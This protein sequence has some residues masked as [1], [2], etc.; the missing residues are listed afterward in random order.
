MGAIL[1]RE[2]N[3][4]GSNEDS[5]WT[6]LSKEVRETDCTT[7][8]LTAE[9]IADAQALKQDVFR[10]Q[11][12]NGGRCGLKDQTGDKVRE[13]TGSQTRHNFLSPKHI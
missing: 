6:E 11:E 7:W 8:K 2:A 10:A 12:V 9:R 1:A 4:G 13:E 3:E 5:I